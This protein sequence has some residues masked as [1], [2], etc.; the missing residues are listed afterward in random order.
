LSGRIEDQEVGNRSLSGRSPE[1]TILEIR[2]MPRIMMMQMVCSD[3]HPERGTELQQ[4]RRTARRHEADG[5]VGTKQQ[6]DQQ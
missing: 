1:G 5:H 2:R 6:G 4:K 3:G